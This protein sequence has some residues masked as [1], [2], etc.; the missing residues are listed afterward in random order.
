MLLKQIDLTDIT[1]L[2]IFGTSRKSPGGVKVRLDAPDGALIGQGHFT[3]KETDPVT[4]AITPGTRKHDVYLVFDDV[5][6][7]ITSI[8]I[9]D[10]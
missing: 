4:V 9:K 8:L 2:E 6:G 10:K 5:G 7:Q 3:G 1:K